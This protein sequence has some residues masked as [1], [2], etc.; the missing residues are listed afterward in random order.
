V[1]LTDNAA[2][3]VAANGAAAEP[4]STQAASNGVHSPEEQAREPEADPAAAE[5]AQQ[6]PAEQQWLGTGVKPPSGTMP[7]GLQTPAQT[8]AEQTAQ[9]QQQQGSKQRSAVFD[10]HDLLPGAPMLHAGDEVEFTLVPDRMGAEPRA[11]RV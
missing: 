10:G 7:P 3:G 6:A 8:P 11:T 9:Q 1:Q 4:G 5:P 2:A